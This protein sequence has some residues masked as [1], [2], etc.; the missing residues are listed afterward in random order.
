MRVPQVGRLARD[1]RGLRPRARPRER[2]H[3]SSRPRRT[4][5]PTARRRRPKQLCYTNTGPHARLRARDRPLQRGPTSRASTSTTP[6]LDARSIRRRPAA[7]PSPPP[8]RPRSPSAPTAGRRA[9]SSPSARRARRS[10][11]ARSPTCRARQRLDGHLRGRTGGS[12]VRRLRLRRHVGGGAAGRRRGRRPAANA[13]HRT[14]SRSSSPRSTAPRL[15]YGQN[16]TE[17]TGR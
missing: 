4:T 8:R 2:R 10:T 9:S 1:D 7:S 12:R 3:R 6:A 11:A 13:I 16:G 14:P 17:K 5:R 15:A